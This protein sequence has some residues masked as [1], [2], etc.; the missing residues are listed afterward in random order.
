MSFSGKLTNYLNFNILPFYLS[1]HMKFS[2]KPTGRVDSVSQC[3]AVG[4]GSPINSKPF[5]ATT[6][7]PAMPANASGE[8]RG[9]SD[10]QMR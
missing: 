3:R 10:T 5:G 6:N 9:T 8:Q 7:V 2:S 4:T 1:Q